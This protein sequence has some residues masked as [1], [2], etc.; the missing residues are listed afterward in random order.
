MICILK[1]DNIEVVIKKSENKYWVNIKSKALT[2]IK[3]Y[4]T[5][6]E[7]ICMLESS[8]SENAFHKIP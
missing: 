1:N 3:E 6:L 5:R 2:V 4:N 7:L 8:F